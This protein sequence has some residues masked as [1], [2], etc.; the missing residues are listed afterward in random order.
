MVAEYPRPVAGCAS[1]VA[2]RVMEAVFGAM[3]MAIPDRMF[4]VLGTGSGCPFH[5]APS[6]G[7]P[8]E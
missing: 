8:G 4:E 2:Q 6:D 3:G 1:E 7:P 5:V